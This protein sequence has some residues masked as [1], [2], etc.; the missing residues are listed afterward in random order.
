MKEITAAYEAWWPDDV[1]VIMVMI[2][3]KQKHSHSTE[4]PATELSPLLEIISQL[5]LLFISR[6]KGVF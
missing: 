4:E 2:Q 6:Y 1:R 3:E 5:T